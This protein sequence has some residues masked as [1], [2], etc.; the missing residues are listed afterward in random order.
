[1]IPRF[2][3]NILWL[4]IVCLVWGCDRGQSKSEEV[5]LYTAVDE[6]VARPIIRE[7]ERQ[8]GISVILRTDAEAT[9]TAG[10]AERLEAEKSNPQA[11]VWWSNE[12]FHTINLAQQKVVAPYASPSAAK[13]PPEFKDKDNF[14]AGTSLRVRVL[15]ASPK[16]PISPHSIYDLTNPALKGKICLSR[17]VAGTA[18]GH[19]AI[20][21]T[22]MGRENFEKY[23]NGL[24]DNQVRLVGGNSIVA[25]LVGSGQMLAGI[26]DND[27][28]D[29]AAREGGKLEMILPDQGSSEIG[30]LAI[31]CTAA[32]VA[33]APHEANAKKLIDYLL[34]QTVEYQ[35]ID[36]HFARYSVL[37]PSAN[38]KFMKVDYAQAAANMKD[39]VE[40]S[41]KIL[42][43]R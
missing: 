36:R 42:E 3:F 24:K 7:F 25:E 6:P 41:L 38:V 4:L 18:K 9:K 13:S 35:L 27:D 10:L 33:G 1:M 43:G 20:L 32:L 23:L 22:T 28:V 12:P 40:L 34:S 8:T 2:L 31:P 19:M 30:A 5:I 29:A 11:D 15:A 26:T 14:W 37:N 16:C 21:Y 17:P 39:A